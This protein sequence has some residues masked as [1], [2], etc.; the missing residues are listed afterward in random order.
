MS[1]HPLVAFLMV[2]LA[3]APVSAQTGREYFVQPDTATIDSARM[4][5]QVAFVVLRDS[6]ASISA[7]G[8]RLMSEM[9]PNSSLAWMHA[10]ARSVA[11]A[12]VRSE[13]PLSEAKVVTLQGSWPREN[14]RKAQADL[15]KGMSAFAQELTA[16]QTRWTG[17]A[18]DTS[19]SQ[20]RDNAP[21][22]M[23]RLQDELDKFNRTAQTY[24]RY[25]SGKLPT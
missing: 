4:V 3:A 20:L 18:A 15:L 23:K 24:L 9:N 16:C 17:F 2:A 14:Q 1:R 8:A 12:C 19:K 25:T 10:R 22:Q 6:T 21:Y 7:A 13:A 11:E 5:Q